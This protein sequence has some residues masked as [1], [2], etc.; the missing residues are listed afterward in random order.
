[1]S[2]TINLMTAEQSESLEELH[3]TLIAILVDKS[4]LYPQTTI[5]SDGTNTRFISREEYL[6]FHI[7]IL[8]EK[9]EEAFPKLGE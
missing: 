9:L 7:G 1:M 6:D 2:K 4:R 3:G 5:G 8:I